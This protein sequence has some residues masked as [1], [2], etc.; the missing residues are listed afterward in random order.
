MTGIKM[1]GLDL[2]G[3]VFDNE[4]HISEENKNAIKEALS[5]GIIVLPATGRPLCGLPREMLQIDG[6][7]YAVTS[8]GG[9]IYDL[10]TRQAIYEDC[11]PNGTGIEIAAAMKAADGLSEVYLDGVCY[12][13]KQ[14]FERALHYPLPPSFIEYMKV[15]RIPVSD[16]ISFIRESGRGIQKMHMIFGSKEARL[17]GFEILKK[18]HDLAVTSAMSFNIEVNKKSADKGNGLLALG[19]LLGIRKEEIMAC[20]DAG[21]DLEMLKKVGFAVAMDNAEP[22]IKAAADVVTKSNEENG[23]ALAIRKYALGQ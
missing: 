5:A 8:N 9:A 17:H 19:R 22:E 18:F 16:L 23:V 1:I 7:R 2:D 12:T 10:K 15:S 21:N 13:D 11:I 6:I 4:K 14:Q 20:G 3:T